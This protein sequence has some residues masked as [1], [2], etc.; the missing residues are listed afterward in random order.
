MFYLLAL[1]RFSL[2]HFKPLPINCLLSL[3]LKVAECM[4]QVAAISS[5]V[6]L[7][8]VLVN[9]VQVLI[10]DGLVVLVLL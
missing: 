9:V 10:Y 7:V 5:C 1:L 4:Q 2:Y 8:H 6:S 3:V